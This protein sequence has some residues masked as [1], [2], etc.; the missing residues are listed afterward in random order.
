VFLAALAAL[1]RPGA[2]IIAHG[3]DPYGTRDPVHTSYHERNRSRG[4]LGGQLRLR[5]RYRELS[6]EWFD[7]LVCSAEE[8]AS[9]VHGTGWRLTDVDDRDK[10]YYLATL[11]L[12]D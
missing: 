10:P 6:T 4:R 3:T 8:F 1:A 11:R 7:Y 12:A 2:Q 5:L 9:L